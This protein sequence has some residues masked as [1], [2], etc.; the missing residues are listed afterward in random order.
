M[1]NQLLLIFAFF[2]IFALASPFEDVTNDLTKRSLLLVPRLLTKRQKLT[3]CRVWLPESRKADKSLRLLTDKWFELIG[4]ELINGLNGQLI[5]HP[6]DKWLKWIDFHYCL[7]NRWNDRST[8]KYLKWIDSLFLIAV[9]LWKE[10]ASTVGLQEAILSGVG[11]YLRS[12]TIAWGVSKMPWY[13]F[14]PYLS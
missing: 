3:T 9:I 6:I 7:I 1:K 8:D 13:R 4:R 11:W 14:F 2:F 10:W 5:V 12:T